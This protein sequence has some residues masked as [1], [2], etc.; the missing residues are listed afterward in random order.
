VLAHEHLD[1][2]RVGGVL[3]VRAGL[4]ALAGRPRRGDVLLNS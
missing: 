4:S 1:G 3:V 2:A